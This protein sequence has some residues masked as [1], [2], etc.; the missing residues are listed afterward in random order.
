M[1]FLSWILIIFLFFVGIYL[2]TVLERYIYHSKTDFLRPWRRLFSLLLQE[3]IKPL[4]R[5]KIF[6]EV[7]PPIFLT[8]VVLA[9]SV[10]PLDQNK[11]VVNMATGGLFLNA[12]LAYIMVAM[13][14]AGWSANGVYSL[15]GGWRFLAQLIAYSMPIVM[16]ITAT[17]M[18]AESINLINIV[19]SQA[20]LWNIIYQPLGFILFYLSALA[21]AFLPPFDLPVAEGE[22][23]GG[24]WS[25]FTGAKLLIFR[26]GRLM[27]ILT[28]SIA[29]VVLFLGGWYG[30]VLPGFAWLFLKSILVAASLLLAGKKFTRLQH[31]QLLSWSW[32]YATPVALFNIFYVGVILLL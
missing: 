16:T 17:V 32:K 15:I 9:F 12:A 29:I 5:D 26:L 30:P 23:A 19:E 10:L 6:Y 20:P 8:A 3:E 27:L 13:L 31:D 28:L 25:E 2:I 14:M 22:L 24:V 21:L 18:R 1:D 4:Q 11:V 7:A